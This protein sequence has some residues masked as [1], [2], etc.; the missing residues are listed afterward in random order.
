MVPWLHHTLTLR[1]RSITIEHISFILKRLFSTFR[2]F[3][4]LFT[5]YLKQM[6]TS[7]TWTQLHI[8]EDELKV[9]AQL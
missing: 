6:N 9:I 7:N 4:V 1:E 2:L 5:L 3:Q 8:K